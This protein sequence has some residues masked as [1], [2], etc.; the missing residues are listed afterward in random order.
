[1]EAMKHEVLNYRVVNSSGAE[2]GS[3]NLDAR[4][5]GVQVNSHVVFEV[6]QSQLASRRQGTHSCL[7]KG[8]MK[9]GGKKPWRQKGTGRARAGSSTSPIWVGGGVAHGPKPRSYSN[10]AAK[11]LRAQALLAV[12]SDKA[13]QGKFVVVDTLNA[14]NAPIKSGKT[15]DFAAFL[16]KL[17]LGGKKVAFLIPAEGNELAMRVSKNITSVEVIAVERVSAYELL[18]NEFILCSVDTLER[19]QALLGQRSFTLG[20]SSLEE[21]AAAAA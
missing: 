6:V 3:V 5:F 7:T 11:R 2:V 16:E 15:K 8:E 9:G 17:G 20:S 18:R 12:L 4:V 19:M 1:M 10:R 14:S 13:T 21:G